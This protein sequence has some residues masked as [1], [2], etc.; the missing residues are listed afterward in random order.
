MCGARV[1]SHPPPPQ[2]PQHP[3]IRIVKKICGRCLGTGTELVGGGTCK[4]CHG[5]LKVRVYYP[6]KKCRGCNGTGAGMYGVSTIHKTC[7]GTGWENA[8]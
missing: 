4:G 1:G 6:P 7:R 3:Q 2:P 5:D 8:V